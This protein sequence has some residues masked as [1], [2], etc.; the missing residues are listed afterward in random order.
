MQDLF[1]MIVGFQAQHEAELKMDEHGLIDE[2]LTKIQSRIP[3]LHGK[4]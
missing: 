4:V 2:L 1:D 3:E